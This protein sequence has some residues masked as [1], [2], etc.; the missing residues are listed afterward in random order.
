MSTTSS[1]ATLVA[2]DGL[3]ACAYLPGRTA[4]LPLEYPLRQ[5]SGE[6]WDAYLA[7][8]Y[9]RTGE[10][11]Y[12]P[13][14][15]E[16]QACEPIR[17]LVN[18]FR[19]NRSQRRAWR[20]GLETFSLEVGRCR[21]D[22]QRIR[23][24]NAHKAARQLDMGEGPIDAEGYHS[25]LVESCCDSLELRYYAD[26]ELAGVAVIDRGQEAMSAVYCY[27]DPRFRGHSL[28][29]FSILQE[30]ALCR[31]WGLKYLY[32]GYYIAEPCRMTYKASFRPHERLRDGQWVRFERP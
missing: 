1:L 26:G 32:L 24:Y 19:P 22:A 28:G 8:G 20:K 2:Y 5:L 17:V 18:E 12:R 4:R 3:D 11:V 14:C 13:T 29:T 23:L 6:E 25:F 30:L 7:A 16:C 21:V 9:R 31:R 15:P 27:F 10:L